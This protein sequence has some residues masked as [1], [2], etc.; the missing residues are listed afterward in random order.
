MVAPQRQ[1]FKKAA[2]KCRGKKLKSYRV[3]MRKELRI[4]GKRRKRRK[5]KV[6]GGLF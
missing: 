1:R 4:K 6:D 5:N 2:K 3:C